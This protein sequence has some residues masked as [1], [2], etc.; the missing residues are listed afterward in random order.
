MDR[1]DTTTPCQSS[2]HLSWF[3][4]KSPVLGAMPLPSP[5]INSKTIPLW[6]TTSWQTYATNQAQPVSR[7][8]STSLPAIMAVTTPEEAEAPHIQMASALYIPGEFCRQGD[9]LQAAAAAQKPVFLERGPFLSPPDLLR[10]LPK[11]S[12]AP[13]LFV[14]EGGSSFGYSDRVFD[15]RA[16]ALYARAGVA[17][18]VHL[19]LLA[20]LWPPQQPRWN[21]D[22][23]LPWQ[24]DP[25]LQPYLRMIS[26]ASGALFVIETAAGDSP[27]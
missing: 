26:Q 14:V 11:L 12:K 8:G 7:T 2:L 5:L 24:V 23:T 3:A 10:A 22:G 13:A 25:Q 6:G 17:F 9:L 15:P 21:P 4:E 20:G 16:C 27:S 1:S 19:A 18:G